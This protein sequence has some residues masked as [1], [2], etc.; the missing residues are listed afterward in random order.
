MP[1]RVRI[2]RRDAHQTMNAALRLQIS[3]S[4]ITF[5]LER[6]RF[7]SGDITIIHIELMNR[8]SAFLRPHNIHAHEHRSPVAAFCSACAGV[9]FKNGSERI[10]FRS[11]G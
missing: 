10:F 6:A 1:L 11:E 8:V 4:K 9:D 7:Y 5:D 2:E 3:I